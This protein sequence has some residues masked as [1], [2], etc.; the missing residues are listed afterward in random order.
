MRRLQALGHLEET[1]MDTM[2]Q[3]AQIIHS[4]LTHRPIDVDMPAAG[5]VA[6]IIAQALADAGLLAVREKATSLDQLAPGDR[7]WLDGAWRTVLS[8]RAHCGDVTVAVDQDTGFTAP[9]ALLVR[10]A[11]Q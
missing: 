4:E 2:Q 8:A 1:V 7:I 6:G 3:A 10:R 9:A 11:E 5:K